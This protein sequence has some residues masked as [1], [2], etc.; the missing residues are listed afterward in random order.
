MMK[1]QKVIYRAKSKTQLAQ[2]YNV[3]LRTFNKWIKP[4]LNEIG[5]YTGGAYAPKQVKIIY[6]K[7]GEP[8][9]F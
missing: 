7:I 8:E 2:A 9:T 4:F 1:E 3:D 5:T 6:D